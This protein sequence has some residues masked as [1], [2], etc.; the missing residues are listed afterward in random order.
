MAYEIKR[1]FV[2][3]DKASGSLVARAR[4]LAPDVWQAM[5]VANDGLK[6]PIRGTG[7][8]PSLRDAL[9]SRLLPDFL[10]ELDAA[11]KRARLD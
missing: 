11:L 3:I 5:S 1:E 4:R 9:A 6:R 7:I 8:A 2:V 10:P